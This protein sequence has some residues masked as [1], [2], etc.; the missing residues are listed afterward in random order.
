M[1]MLSMK[2]R[3]QKPNRRKSKL[4]MKS[5]RKMGMLSKKK[6]SP[7]PNRRR[8]KLKMKSL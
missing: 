3:S 4:K 1:G 2:K 6:Q 8:S 7:K 5:L